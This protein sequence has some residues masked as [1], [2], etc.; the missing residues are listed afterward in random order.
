MFKLS[1]NK[2]NF[3]R[4]IMIEIPM[5]A[6]ISEPNAGIKI[7]VDGPPEQMELPI[8]TPAPARLSD[9]AHKFIA[10]WISGKLPFRSQPVPST[11]LFEVYEKSCRNNTSVGL[12]DF[13]LAARSHGVAVAHGRFMK[14]KGLQ[15]ARVLF[16]PEAVRPPGMTRTAWLTRCIAEFNTSHHGE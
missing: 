9:S 8:D 12:R 6:D 14:G 10:D 4:R 3:C 7:T 13:V 5:F 2:K 1:M 16:P 11:S 15:Q